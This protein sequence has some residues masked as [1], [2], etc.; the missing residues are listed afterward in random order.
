MEP[1]QPAEP[2]TPEEQPVEPVEPKQPEQCQNGY[3]Q[4]NGTCIAICM[5]GYHINPMNNSE[6]VASCPNGWVDLGSSCL[7]PVVPREQYLNREECMRANQNCYVLESTTLWWT[8]NIYVG[9]CPEGY[10]SKGA[11]ISTQC[12]ALCE[13]N[14]DVVYTDASESQRV[15]L[16]ETYAREQYDVIT[17]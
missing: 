12:S 9:D 6:C 3:I 8:Y 11:T 4:Y 10:G 13:A 14:D 1:V 5:P 2:E 17:I 15:C 16:R 7:P